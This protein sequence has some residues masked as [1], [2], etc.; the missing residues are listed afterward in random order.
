M[1]KAVA[2][3]AGNAEAHDDLGVVYAQ[4]KKFIQAKLHFESAIRSDRSYQ[5]AYHNLAMVHYI[6]G[7]NQVALQTVNR[8]LKLEPHSRNSL[9]LKATI[10]TA[11]GRHAEAKKAKGD[12]DFLPEGNWSERSPVN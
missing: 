11:L 10:L 2:L 5:K 4:R 8:A 12:A 3:D 7:Q 6:N 9:L 1:K